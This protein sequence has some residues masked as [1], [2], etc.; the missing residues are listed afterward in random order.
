M[1]AAIVGIRK[2]KVS[3]TRGRLIDPRT[4]QSTT[5]RAAGSID[6]N[7]WINKRAPKRLGRDRNVERDGFR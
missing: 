6:I 4:V 5:M 1:R 7:H 3:R 2:I